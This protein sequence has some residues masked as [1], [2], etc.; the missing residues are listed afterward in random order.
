M[1]ASRRVLVVGSGGREHALAWKL[2]QDGAEV[3]VAPGNAGTAAI[4]ENVPVAATDTGTAPS[5]QFTRSKWWV[6]LC[7]NSPPEIFFC[8]CHL[9]K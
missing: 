8:E 5:H 4:A 6:D 1:P 7:T 9:R 3:L 2:I